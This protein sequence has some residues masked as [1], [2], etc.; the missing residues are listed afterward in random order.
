MQ[1]G[2]D[3]LN[4]GFGTDTAVFTGNF[5][6]YAFSINSNTGAIEIVDGNAG[7]DGTDTAIKIESFIFNDQTY[8]LGDVLNQTSFDKY[9]YLASHKD[10]LNHFGN[11][12]DAAF[13]HY[14]NFG[15]SEERAI[16]TFNDWGYLASN[17]DLLN[18]R[19]D[20]AAA[21]QHYV[22]HGYSESRSTDSFITGA[23]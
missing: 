10:L 4:G 13:N 14:V 18:H 5:T 17:K 16:D 22:N 19:N 3:T 2:D 1:N 21:T 23:I 12:A 7:R 11:D 20:T 9:S 6:D 15:Q 8:G